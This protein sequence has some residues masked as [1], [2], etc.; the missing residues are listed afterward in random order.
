MVQVTLVG[1]SP[2]LRYCID[3]EIMV[4]NKLIDNCILCKLMGEAIMKKLVFLVGGAT[5]FVGRELVP[6]LANNYQDIEVRALTRDPNS[7]LSLTFAKLPQ[8]KVIQG[9]YD[10]IDSLRQAAQGVDRAYVACNN[11]DKQFEFECNFI[12]ACKSEN[13]SRIIKLASLKHLCTADGPAH[14]G[15]HYRI[16]EHLKKSNI[17]YAAIYPTCFFQTTLYFVPFIK[18]QGVLPH[19]LGDT[20]QHLTDCRDI[21]QYIAALLTCNDETFAGFN[22]KPLIIAGP[23]KLSGD[24]WAATLRRHGVN[25]TYKKIGPE[26]FKNNFLSL[27][28]PEDMVKNITEFHTPFYDKSIPVP[29]QYSSPEWESL[30]GIPKQ[31]RRYDNFIKEIAPIFKD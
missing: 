31:Y 6:Y 5:G 3:N 19:L 1:I 18:A 22:G 16:V 21:A 30:P 4:I 12:D 17:P 27:G 26:E 25:A 13:V 28:I 20:E 14:G 11:V 9:D 10:D 29:D 7:D 8:V 2:Y 23:D 24:G 15:A